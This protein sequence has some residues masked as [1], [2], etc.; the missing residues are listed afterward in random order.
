MHIQIHAAAATVA[1]L[2]GPLPIYRKRRDRLHKVAGYIWVT[3]MLAVAVTAF[4]IHSFAVI[5]PFSPLHGFALLTLWSL[6]RGIDAAR[7]GDIVVHEATLRSLY[8]FGLLIAGLANFLPD[9]RI[10]QMFFDGQD[11]LGWIVIALGGAALVGLALKGRLGR[12]DTR[13]AQT[14]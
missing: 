3:A 11:Q 10:N 2:L 5:G 12:P 7:R 1:V 6:W 4:F 13:A 9:R 14:T 8:W